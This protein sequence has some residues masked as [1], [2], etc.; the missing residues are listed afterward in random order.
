[1]AWDAAGIGP[2]RGRNE[3]NSMKTESTARRRDALRPEYDLS[4]LKGGVRG[5]YHKSART[6]TNLVLIEP[7]KRRRTR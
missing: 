1:M 6:G 2:D 5:K 7:A 4:E 3:H